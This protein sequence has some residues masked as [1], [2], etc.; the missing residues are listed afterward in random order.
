MP[1][2]FVYLTANF[3]F[4]IYAYLRSK[5]SKTARAGTPYYIGKGKNNRAWGLHC[6]GIVKVPKDHSKIVIMESNLSEIGAFALERRYIKWFGRKDD[7]TGILVNLTAGGDGTCGLLFS[8]ERKLN[9]KIACNK[10]AR[11]AKLSKSHLEKWADPN[12][13]FNQPSHKIK[14]S[15]AQKLVRMDENCI[16]NSVEY[17]QKISVAS[18]KAWANET[19]GCNSP[20]YRKL[21]S[22]RAKKHWLIIN[23]SGETFEVIGLKNFCKEHNLHYVNLHATSKNKKTYQGWSCSLL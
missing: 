20:E 1:N 9:H 6:H 3:K 19:S 21:I 23:P 13:T 22:E 7:G 12:S 2:N 8:E 18:K 17:K 4:Y 11:R 5:D 16:F 10:P 14:L 15:K